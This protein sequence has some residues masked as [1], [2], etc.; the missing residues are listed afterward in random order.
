MGQAM[1]NSF[2]YNN[3]IKGEDLECGIYLSPLP[4]DLDQ[5]PF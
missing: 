3:R 1:E 5:C 4:G 2:M